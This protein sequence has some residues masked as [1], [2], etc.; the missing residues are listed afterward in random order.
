MTSSLEQTPLSGAAATNA[1]CIACKQAKSPSEYSKTQVI[2]IYGYGISRPWRATTARTGVV[3]SNPYF[4]QNMKLPH[5]RRCKACMADI[6]P[7]AGGG[8]GGGGG[9][10]K[11][12][13]R[14]KKK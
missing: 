4:M 3:H 7:A 10:K 9:K 1:V 12:W 11:K 2:I 14:K 5:Q 8:G 6:E 13:G